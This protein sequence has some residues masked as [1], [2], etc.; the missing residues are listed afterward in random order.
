MAAISSMGL[1]FVAGLTILMPA[2]YRAGTDHV[3]THSIFQIWIDAATGHSHH[4][5]KHHHDHGDALAG[6]D[7][8][9]FVDA[10]TA[11]PVTSHMPIQH[12]DVL[13][14]L[15]VLIALLLAGASL[16]P[17]WRGDARL[18]GVCHRLDPP[19]PRLAPC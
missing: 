13:G 16:R 5:H 4:H 9:M 17:V 11:E 1:A 10:D 3:H 14:A 18:T 7:T 2:D 15:S 8:P 12:A 19:P 6:S